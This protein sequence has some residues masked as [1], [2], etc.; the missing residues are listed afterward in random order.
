MDIDVFVCFQQL[1][2]IEIDEVDEEKLLAGSAIAIIALG[3]IEAHRLRTERRQPSRLYLCRPQLL[4]NP[5]GKPLHGRYC[6]DHEM[7]GRTSQLW[8]LMLRLSTQSLM[9]DLVVERV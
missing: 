3:V 6:I 8:A 2:E 5:R 1:E 9:R 7:T 4:Q